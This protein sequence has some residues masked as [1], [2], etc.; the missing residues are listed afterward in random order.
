MADDVVRRLQI[1]HHTGYR[2]SEVVTAS[3][4]EVR[5]TPADSSGQVLISH[6][7]DVT[8]AGAVQ[9][10]ADYWGALVEAFDVHVAHTVLKVTSTSVVLTAPQAVPVAPLAWEQVRDRRVQDRY[11]EFLSC[12]AYVD[13]AP[14]DSRAAIVDRMAACR[15]PRDAAEVAVASVREHLS[16]VSGATSV[17]TLA[18]EAWQA[19]TGVCQDFTHATLSLLRSIAIPARYVSGYLHTEEPS[20]G[21]TVTGES[22][23]WVEFWD[24]GWIA[25][26][27][28]NDRLVGPGHVI[29]ARGRDYADV[30]PLK[31]IYSGGT[32]EGIGVTVEITQLAG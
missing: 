3:F 26:D 25:V 13:V 23:A 7:L 11:A 32:S 24:G 2:Y 20:L 19:G 28:T 30:P 27:P 8:P 4:N 29:V 15:T 9:S 1:V 18:S 16:Y 17:N 12:S 14:D 10:Y 22:H 31:G 21:A 5:M 6:R